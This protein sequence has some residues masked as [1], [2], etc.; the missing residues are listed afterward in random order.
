MS[1]EVL[2]FFIYFSSHLHAH[3][4]PMVCVL[5]NRLLSVHPIS[6]GEYGN[7]G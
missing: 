6:G 5:D 3:T 2:F 7:Q 1:F 4:Q